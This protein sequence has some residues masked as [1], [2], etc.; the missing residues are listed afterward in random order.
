VHGEHTPPLTSVKPGSQSH[1]QL[2]LKSATLISTFITHEALAG[3]PWHFAHWVLLR[4]LHGAATYSPAARH[5]VV[6]GKQPVPD[7][8]SV[9][10]LQPPKP[11]TLEGDG[12]GP[13]RSYARSLGPCALARTSGSSG[14]AAPA[15]LAR[16]TATRTPAARTPAA[17]MRVLIAGAAS[18]VD[19]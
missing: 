7:Q 16:A 18:T 5:V 11:R 12:D 17:G 13:D 1:V 8:N 9:P 6:Q 10:F 4:S 15:A 14:C 19:L 3:F 2:A